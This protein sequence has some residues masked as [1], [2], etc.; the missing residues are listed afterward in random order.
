MT[1][2]DY[3]RNDVAKSGLD[4]ISISRVTNYWNE[5]PRLTWPILYSEELSVTETET[6]GFRKI[7]K[8]KSEKWFNWNLK[9]RIRS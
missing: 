8:T 2:S 4:L 9:W 5:W 1:D 7:R 3:E 6:V